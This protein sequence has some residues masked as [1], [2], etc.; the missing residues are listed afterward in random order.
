MVGGSAITLEGCSAE[1]MAA[2]DVRTRRC[3]EDRAPAA[4]RALKYPIVRFDDSVEVRE[5]L[6]SDGVL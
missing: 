2:V 1:V 6:C 3:G 4:H 5:L